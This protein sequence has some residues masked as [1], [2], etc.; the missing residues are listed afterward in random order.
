MSINSCYMCDNAHTN[1]DLDHN[2]DLSSVGVAEKHSTCSI[3][4]T[5]GDKRK[6]K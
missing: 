5:S 3:F 1:D 4:L 2:N 6:L